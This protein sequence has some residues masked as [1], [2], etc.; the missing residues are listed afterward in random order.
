MLIG[1]VETIAANVLEYAR[2]IAMQIISRIETITGAIFCHSSCIVPRYLLPQSAWPLACGSMVRPAIILF[3]FCALRAQK[4][5]RKS[6]QYYTQLAARRCG[7]LVER[8]LDASISTN[9][10]ARAVHLARWR[11]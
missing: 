9:Q 7:Q 6:S 3:R 10:P 1:I 4:R 2:V 11:L 8:K 5:K